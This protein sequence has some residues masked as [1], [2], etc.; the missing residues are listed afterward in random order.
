MSEIMNRFISATLPLTSARELVVVPTVAS[1]ADNIR[2]AH[3]NCMTALADSLREAIIAGHALIAL[4]A[5]L[6]KDKAPVLWLDYVAIEC[7]LSARTA[8]NYMHL[9]KHE[10]LLAPWLSTE[11]QGSAFSQAAALRFLGDERKKRK[12]KPKA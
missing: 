2:K 4:K 9:A 1:L 5:Q 7:G 10:A 12:R 3:H 6:K 8:Q 11:A